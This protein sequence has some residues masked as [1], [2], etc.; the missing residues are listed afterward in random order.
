M[1]RFFL[2]TS[3]L[4]SNLVFGSVWT[5][6]YKA[7]V[8]QAKAEKKDLLVFFTGSDWCP[9]CQ[10]LDETILSKDAFEKEAP[11]HFVLVKADFPKE[12]EQSDE[13][14]E[15]NKALRKKYKVRGYPTLVLASSDEAAYTTAGTANLSPEDYVKWLAQ[16]KGLKTFG[17]AYEAKKYDEALVALDAFRKTEG[18]LPSLL[19][20]ALTF[21]VVILDKQGKPKPEIIA[22]LEEAI[23]VDPESEKAEV[24][25][26]ALDSLKEQPDNR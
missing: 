9:Y 7:A 20:H 17:F 3:L 23:N 6:D 15:Q 19:Q 16:A 12:I 21:R 1:T 8:E 4:I 5:E 24:L 10:E 2:L 13:L 26:K 25:K 11:K 18:L 14:V 22:A